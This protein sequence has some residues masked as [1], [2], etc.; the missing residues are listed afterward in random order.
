MWIISHYPSE[1]PKRSKK[2][3]TKTE[4]RLGWLVHPSLKVFICRFL[5]D[6]GHLESPRCFV[7]FPVLLHHPSQGP[8]LLRPQH[9]QQ[10]W[11]RMPQTR[12]WET[13]PCSLAFQKPRKKKKRPPSK[14]PSKAK[15]NKP[16]EKQNQDNIFSRNAMD[17]RCPQFCRCS[18]PKPLF[19]GAWTIFCKR[20]PS[21]V[22]HST[23]PP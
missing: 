15:N 23:K 3:L 7:R 2:S 12:S 4:Q 10:L 8:Q 5:W 11:L 9:V 17:W 22:F 21:K 6:W 18:S 19:Q 16:P 14:R 13:A 1:H 20:S